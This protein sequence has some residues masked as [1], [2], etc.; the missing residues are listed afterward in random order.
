LDHTNVWNSSII[1]QNS[2]ANLTLTTGLSLFLLA[3]VDKYL[4]DM[5]CP[6]GKLLVLGIHFMIRRNG[7]GLSKKAGRPWLQYSTGSEASPS[8]CKTMTCNYC[9]TF[10]MVKGSS[11]ATNSFIAYKIPHVYKWNCICQC[12]I[13]TWI[14]ENNWTISNVCVIRPPSALNNVVL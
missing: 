4:G 7:S 12:Q 11:S 10:S 5:Y 14:L 8:T 1:F 6:W 9:I 13:C 2:S 3:Q